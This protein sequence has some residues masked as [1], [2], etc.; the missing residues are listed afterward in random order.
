MQESI[1][2][3]IRN[4]KAPARELLRWSRRREW[5]R[6]R[7]IS[8]Q[9]KRHKWQQNYTFRIMYIHKSDSDSSTRTGEFHMKSGILYFKRRK[10]TKNS[11]CYSGRPLALDAAR[12]AF[13]VI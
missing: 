4:P 9:S 8:F 6:A 2:S 3:L 11:V 10:F 1:H 12:C 5:A 13:S 7:R